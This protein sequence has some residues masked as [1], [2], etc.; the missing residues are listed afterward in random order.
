MFRFY[1][2]YLVLFLILSQNVDSAPISN[3]TLTDASVKPN[4]PYRHTVELLETCV[5][6]LFLAV[7]GALHLNVDPSRSWFTRTWKKLP[8]VM[9]GM[10]FPELVLWTAI[11]QLIVA[12][13]IRKT[14]K[15]ISRNPDV[16]PWIFR[17]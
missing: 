6:T 7:Y 5:A 12:H 3:S 10:A 15:T 13:K 14:C 17:P 8:W 4:P 11:G 2:P 16:R 9:I 1:L